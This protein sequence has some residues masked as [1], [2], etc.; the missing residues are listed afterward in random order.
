MLIRCEKC[1]ALYSLQDGVVRSA[2][3]EVPPSFAVECGRCLNQFEADGPSAFRPSVRKTPAP[4]SGSARGSKPK[5][6]GGAELPTPSAPTTASLA[7]ALKPQRP[8]V[9]SDVPG[10]DNAFEREL[11]AA[12]SRRK[13][14]TVLAVLIILVVIGVVAWPMIHK[15][16]TA[17]PAAAVAKIEQAQKKMLL[18]D[19]ASLEQAAELDQQAIK[20][21]PGDPAP[22][23]ARAFALLLSAGAHKDLADR[24]EAR[25]A[26]VSDEMAKLQLSKPEGYEKQVEALRTEMLAVNDE[27]DPQVRA[28]T[29]LLQAGR[30]AARTAL[31]NDADDPTALRAM[32]LYSALSNTVENGVT[33]VDRSDSLMPG[34][35]WTP[36]VRAQL[37]LAG[38]P[39]RDKQDK[40]LGQLALV[41]QAEPHLLRALYDTASVESERKLLAPALDKLGKLLL[42]NPAHQRALLLKKQLTAPPPPPPPPPPAADAIPAPPK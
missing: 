18:D 19:F 2:Q 13:I 26:V 35:P 3:G 32:A 22:Q 36:Y 8:E 9:G 27:R 25:V 11:A 28:A 1:L 42:E 39:S 23:A 12:A 15:R 16:L 5:P 7:K 33:F 38:S 14:F 4:P 34:D 41:R 29:Q 6:S 17:T 21:A 24:G 10:D 31:D 37:F 30:T 40:G 20:L